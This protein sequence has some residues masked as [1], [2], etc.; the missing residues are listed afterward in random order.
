MVMVKGLL[1]TCALN[2]ERNVDECCFPV[3]WSN[4]KNKDNEFCIKG[5]PDFK[6]LDSITAVLCKT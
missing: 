4:S 1:K 5:L 3:K 2:I 6:T